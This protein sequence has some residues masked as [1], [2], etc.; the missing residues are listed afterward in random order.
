MILDGSSV[1][2][3]IAFIAGLVSFFAPCVFP[4][5]PAYIGFFTGVAATDEELKSKRNEILKYSLIFVSGF[6]IVFLLLGLSATSLGHAFA[7]NRAVFAKIGGVVMVLLGMY[8]LGVFKNPAIYRELKIDLHKKLTKYQSVNAFIFGLTFGFAW[9]PCIGPVLAVILLWA[10]QASS[11]LVGTALL[12]AY[13]LGIGV[14]FILIGLFIDKIMPWIRK[15]AKIQQYV[16]TI[17]GA[18]ILIFG[19]MLLTNTLGYISA[20]LLNFGSLEL[21]LIDRI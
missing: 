11:A 15:T 5:V 21:Y 6:L 8:L 12:L 3:G 18:L 19:I 1:N 16:H 9:T 4:L 7:V 14:P 13:G 2:F 20:Y 17:A 10:S